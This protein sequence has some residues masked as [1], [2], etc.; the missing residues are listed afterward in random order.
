MSRWQ[1]NL[2]TG[3]ETTDEHGC[4]A[5][6]TNPSITHTVRHGN[7]LFIRVYPWFP[8]SLTRVSRFNANVKHRHCGSSIGTPTD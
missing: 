5:A 4:Q 2:E 6:M 7:T 1:F 8:S 3:I